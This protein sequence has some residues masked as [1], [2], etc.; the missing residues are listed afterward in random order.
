MEDGVGLLAKQDGFLLAHVGLG[1]DA[2]CALG[3]EVGCEEEDAVAGSRVEGNLREG[4]AR[5]EA[6]AVEK[7]GFMGVVNSRGEGEAGEDGDG[8][9]WVMAACEVGVGQV[10]AAGAEAALEV[11]EGLGIA[12]LLERH[13][14]RVQVREQLGDL[15]A[16]GHGL[17]GPPVCGAHEV[18]FGVERGDAEAWLGEGLR[19]EERDE[20]EKGER[21]GEDAV[22]W[23]REVVERIGGVHV[24]QARTVLVTI[25][26]PGNKP[27][28]GADEG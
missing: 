27:I 23:R 21:S 6:S 2:D 11:G 8:D 26:G 9:V 20:C 12:D 13:D 24:V 25:Q 22:D 16:L 18:V 15:A 5:A 7:V 10:D 28:G 19:R 4:A 14:V 17:D 1:G 3:L